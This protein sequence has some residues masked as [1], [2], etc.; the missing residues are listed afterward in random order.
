MG[1]A[2]GKGQLIY[3][4][5]APTGSRANTANIW[6]RSSDS[7][8]HR[9]DETTGTWVKVTDPAAVAAA[10][11]AAAAQQTA[12]QATTAAAN[13]MAEARYAPRIASR[14]PT[15][16]DGT[17]KPVGAGWNE[18][19]TSG[20]L[21]QMWRW[22][23]TAWQRLNMSPTMIPVLQIGTGT[24]GDLT[25]DRVTVTGDFAAR[26]AT[27]IELNADRITS[28]TIAT[29]RLNA[30]EIAAAVASVI[31]LDAG[32]ITAGTIDTARLNATA[33]A[34]AV[35]TVIQL[36][37]SRITTGTLDTAR[38]N[39][40][41]VAAAVANVI[42]LNA[43]RI[44]AG[45]IAT[46]R[47]DTQGI[48]AAVATIIELNA[49]R[50]TTG[51]LGADRIAANSITAAKILVDDVL[52]A[53]IVQAMDVA[54]KRLVVTEDAILN[55]ATII[56]GLAADV[57]SAATI[58][59]SQLVVAA[60]DEDGN[61]KS[62]TVDTVQIVDGAVRAA[63][64]H[65]EEVAGA[66]ARFLTIE[67]GQLT[68]GTAAIDTLVA[69]KIAAGTASF[70]E[71]YIQ[72]LRTNGAVIDAAV[73]GDLA[74]NIIT[75]GLF[76]TAITG[77]RLEIDSN[78][79]VMYG[80]DDDGN[81]YELVRIGPSGENLVTIGDTTI[82]PDGIATP[83]L[84][85]G[86][87]S[88]NGVT[89][90][91]MIGVAPQGVVA[92]AYST[93]PAAWDGTGN[94]LR[95][96][97][98]DAVLQPGRRYSVTLDQHWARLRTGATSTTFVE[99]LRFEA[100]ASAS[101]ATTS[102][103]QLA[104]QRSFL[105]ASTQS[106][107]MP[108]LVGWLD[109]ADLNLSAERR[110]YFLFTTRSA[111]GRDARIEAAS[112]ETLRL[113]VRDEGPSVPSSGRSWMDQGT[114]SEGS[115][116]APPAVPVKV[117]R[118]EKFAATRAESWNR[119]AGSFLS[120]KSGTVYQGK[121]PNVPAREGA[122]WFNS[123]NG[124]LAGATIKRVQLR[125]YIDHTYWGAGGTADIR[126]HGKTGFTTGGL[127]TSIR[128]MKVKRK[129]QYSIDVPTSYLDGFRTGTWRGFGLSTSSTNLEY[130]V[131]ATLANAEIW[132]TYEK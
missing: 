14:A 105:Q 44:T 26:L 125:F 12:D 3:Q 123:L 16:A 2:A 62:G 65:A 45:T 42:N 24:A 69:Q 47:L 94:E 120:G 27:I 92:W 72:N 33:V 49:S 41:T 23:G 35:A 53:K 38:L 81:D 128:T 115:A 124:N 66:V 106:Q 20:L 10:Q 30:A 75:S 119:G 11:A 8:V 108:P 31:E 113:T 18:Y 82:A 57:V 74:A 80:Q 22:D 50:I 107:T 99:F 59:A 130:Y 85:A 56:N 54:T 102:S 36:N 51:T 25:A 43:S 88:V 76:R 4:A 116:D 48:A 98:V 40:T 131:Q 5:T 109:T 61:L 70:Q 7:Q 77:Q 104:V 97:Q 126:L 122:W 78:G 101:E 34:A 112:G 84:E 71:A 83:S 127:D 95:R 90:Q 117:V 9:Y 91:D 121:Y 6:V 28:G 15:V 32:R 19:N 89:V 1:I 21:V 118:T 100:G 111:G 68:A 132:I 96:L 114:P 103:S 55:R 79:L 17:S 60:L 58:Y 64:I 13:A 129:A 73:I 46:A 52:A 63:Q 87:V 37:A 29:G 110:V 86:A 93:Y 39:A 67:V